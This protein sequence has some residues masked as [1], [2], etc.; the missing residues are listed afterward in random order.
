MFAYINPEEKKN[1]HN[2]NKNQKILQCINSEKKKEKKKNRRRFIDISRQTFQRWNKEIKERDKKEEK[3][4]SH[5]IP[6]KPEKK[7][8]ENFFKQYHVSS[9]KV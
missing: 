8:K 9:T 7:K 2:P 4:K 1:Q 3:R 6:N 5:K